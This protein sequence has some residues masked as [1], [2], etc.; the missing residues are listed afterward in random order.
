MQNLHLSMQLMV[1][2]YTQW[3]HLP[4]KNKK[5]V[6][7]H[8]MF[9]KLYSHIYIFALL[10]YVE[11]VAIILSYYASTFQII[12]WF[13]LDLITLYLPNSQI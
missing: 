6:K 11:K 2:P 10:S 5:F 12:V 1:E 9:E 13:L 8:N 4:S 7:V 3:I